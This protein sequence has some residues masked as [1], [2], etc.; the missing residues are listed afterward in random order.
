MS[1]A[2]TVARNEVPFTFNERKK[3]KGKN[4]GEVY[5]APDFS[6]TDEAL[7][8]KWFGPEIVK[9]MLQKKIN[10]IAQQAMDDITCPDKDGEPPK[11]FD[12]DRFISLVS[13]LKTTSGE[14]LEEMED[15]QMEL[16]EELTEMHAEL[17]EAAANMAS[18]P[19]KFLEV[20]TRVTSLSTKI[21]EIGSQ[22]EARKERFKNVGRKA[23][24]KVEGGTVA[25]ATA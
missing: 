19:E 8:L 17:A 10:Q 12:R 2:I 22:I 23:G 25:T 1:E 13:E 9:D 5:Y 11:P 3:K 14:K 20:S 21:S 15:R 18:N 16:I 24:S 7:V 4:A 6:K